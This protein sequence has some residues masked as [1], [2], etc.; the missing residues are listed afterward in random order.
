MDNE[1][2]HGNLSK[3]KVVQ[4]LLINSMHYTFNNKSLSFH[5]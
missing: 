4:A 1:R 3:L 2:E 5:I